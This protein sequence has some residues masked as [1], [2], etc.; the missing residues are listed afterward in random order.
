VPGVCLGLRRT[1]FECVRAWYSMPTKYSIAVRNCLDVKSDIQSPQA[2]HPH[3][4]RATRAWPLIKPNPRTR[5]PL[6]L[7]TW[8]A[9]TKP[10][11]PRHQASFKEESAVSAPSARPVESHVCV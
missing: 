1:S 6:S 4:T 8:G 5:T 11:W 3:P 9:A 2:L 7:Q 10:F